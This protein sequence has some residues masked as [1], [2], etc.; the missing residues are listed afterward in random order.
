MDS[1]PSSCKDSRNLQNIKRGVEPELLAAIPLDIL[2]LST[3]PYNAD[4]TERWCYPCKAFKYVSEFYVRGK[5]YKPQCKQCSKRPIEVS[6]DY[7]LRQNYRITLEEYDLLF[8]QQGGVCAICKQSE[9]QIDPYTGK[10]KWLAVDHNH[11]LNQ[12]R[13][14]LCQVCNQL[15]GWVEKDR[16]LVKQAIIYLKKHDR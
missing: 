5:K 6:R 9:T 15:V 4:R 13:E 14:L 8:F 10:V 11:E 12:V 16:E 2:N 3:F 1:I 7:N